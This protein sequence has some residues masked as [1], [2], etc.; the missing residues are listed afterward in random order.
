MLSL[1]Q[2]YSYITANKVNTDKQGYVYYIKI[3]LKDSSLYKIGYTGR[4]IV[5][6][7]HDFRL[8]PPVTIDI[9]ASIK[10]PLP[11]AQ[12]FEA[13]LHTRHRNLYNSYTCSQLSINPQPLHSG[14]TELYLTDVLGLDTGIYEVPNYTTKEKLIGS[15][16]YCKCSK[17]FVAE[18]LTE[19]AAYCPRAGLPVTR[20]ARE[21]Y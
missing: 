8:R 21:V 2:L 1:E 6:R 3:N 20:V 4:E 17:S 10:L 13:I 15:N 9:V 5:K 19:H 14:N 12:R 7:L 18:N 16:L 11:E